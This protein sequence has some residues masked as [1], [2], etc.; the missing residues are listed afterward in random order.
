MT[1]DASN[2]EHTRE[3]EPLTGPRSLSSTQAEAK[4]L[5]L[6]VAA[7]AKRIGVSSSKIYQLVAERRIAHFRVGGKTSFRS[8]FW[9]TLLV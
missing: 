3:R 5:P 1:G 9:A 7:A 8:L 2:S 4:E 6:T